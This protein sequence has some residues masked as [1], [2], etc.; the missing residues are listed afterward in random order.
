[1]PISGR[2]LLHGGQLGLSD[3]GR[4]LLGFFGGLKKGKVVTDLPT[5]SV[6]CITCGNNKC[7]IFVCVMDM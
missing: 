1:M 4:H 6:T 3:N 7:V 5:I 2:I